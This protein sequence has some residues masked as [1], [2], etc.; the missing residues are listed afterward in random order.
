MGLTKSFE[1][2][3][4]DQRATQQAFSGEEAF[5]PDD[6]AIFNR[7]ARTAER[8]GKIEIRKTGNTWLLRKVKPMELNTPNLEQTDESSKSVQKTPWRVSLA[9]MKRRI[10]KVEY[11]HPALIPH[12]T[13]A[14]V[15]LDNGYA[16]QGKSAPADPAN[17]NEAKGK[18]Y[19]LEDALRQ[20]WA[21]E[22]YV[23]REHLSGKVSVAYPD[24]RWKE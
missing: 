6:S 19:A 9:A 7:L 8:D 13:I 3:M 22:A 21:L 2:F 5:N 4:A 10:D 24:E 17:F 15:L 16:L 18:E 12:M 23:M 1:T 20:L 11:I 14:V